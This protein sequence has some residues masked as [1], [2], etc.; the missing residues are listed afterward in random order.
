[1]KVESNWFSSKAELNEFI[2]KQRIKPHDVISIC[3]DYQS[4]GITLFYWKANCSV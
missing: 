3:S 2:E 1:M 4:Q